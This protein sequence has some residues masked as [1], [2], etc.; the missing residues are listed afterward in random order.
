MAVIVSAIVSVIASIWIFEIDWRFLP[1]PIF[2]GL[3][4]VFVQKEKISYKFID[5]LFVGS[6]F[7]GFLTLLL[8]YTRMYL[9]FSDFPFWPF[10]NPKEYLIFSLVFSFISFLGGLS[11]IVI[12]GFYYMAHSF[13]AES[14]L[15]IL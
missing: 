6:L 1:F 9:L 8:I 2:A 7:F 15:F 3:A 12:K 4:I 14:R 5:K 10:Y 13:V 11:G